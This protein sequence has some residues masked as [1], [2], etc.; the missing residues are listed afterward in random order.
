LKIPTKLSAHT[1]ITCLSRHWDYHFVTQVGNH[2]RL[3]TMIPR[4]QRITIPVQNELHERLL[5]AVFLRVGAHKR[6]DV[7]KI[8]DT[9]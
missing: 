6:V 7:D 4:F 1:V 3:E 8:L 5:Q 2:V 9:L